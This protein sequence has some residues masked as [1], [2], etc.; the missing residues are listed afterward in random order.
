MNRWWLIDVLTLLLVLAGAMHLGLLGF[1][2]IDFVSH[3][4][5]E[6][7]KFAYDLIGL[8]ALWQISRQRL[9]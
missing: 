5:G 6:R 9:A 7:T 2:D 1:F 3:L 4:F 8:A